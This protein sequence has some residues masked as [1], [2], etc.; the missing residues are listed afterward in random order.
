MNIKA[1][2][3]AIC[4][5]GMGSITFVPFDILMSMK[6][7]N[8]CVLLYA[9]ETLRDNSGFPPRLGLPPRKLTG[10]PGRKPEK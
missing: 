8:A 1:G 2:K 9:D 4:A 7:T 10:F 3:C 5:C 6:W